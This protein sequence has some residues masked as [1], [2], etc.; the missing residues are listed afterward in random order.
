VRWIG[1]LSG[2]RRRTERRKKREKQKSKFGERKEAQWQR[3]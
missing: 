1:R 2:K 3:V